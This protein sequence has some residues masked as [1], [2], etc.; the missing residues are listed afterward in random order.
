MQQK[1]GSP[2]K[3]IKTFTF[4]ESKVCGACD[5]VRKK[6]DQKS[7]ETYLKAAC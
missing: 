5:K 2:A 3:D 4:T 1:I 7:L 6:P